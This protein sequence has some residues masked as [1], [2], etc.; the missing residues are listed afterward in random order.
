MFIESE[1]E[2]FVERFRRAT[3]EL[4]SGLLATRSRL[5]QEMESLLDTVTS[6]DREIARH[7]G[8]ILRQ[9][10]DA[11]ALSDDAMVLSDEALGGIEQVLVGLERLESRD[12]DWI[13]EK[14]DALLAHFDIEDPRRRQAREYVES[15]TEECFEEG[16]ADQR[17]AELL[18]RQWEANLLSA[19]YSDVWKW[20]RSKLDQL[21]GGSGDEGP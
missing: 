10:E 2:E 16:L 17:I 4:E 8:Q 15:F 20:Y 18:T 11:G 7:L 3:R 1:G 21:G 5:V 19:A 12:L 14:I 6:M 13:R 9:A